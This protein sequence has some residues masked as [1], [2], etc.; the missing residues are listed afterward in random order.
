L[1]SGIGFIYCEAEIEPWP[2][3]LGQGPTQH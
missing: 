1:G 2:L 3:V